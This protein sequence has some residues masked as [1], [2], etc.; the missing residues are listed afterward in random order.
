MIT[1]LSC[2]ITKLSSAPGLRFWSFP[3]SS[4]DFLFKG[5]FSSWGIIIS[6][7]S[8]VV[9]S[10]VDSGKVWFAI[11]PFWQETRQQRLSVSAQWDSVLNVIICLS[12]VYL[13]TNQIADSSMI[14]KT[15]IDAET[16]VIHLN[17]NLFAC[18]YWN[19]QAYV[20]ASSPRLEW[21]HWARNYHEAGTFHQIQHYKFQPQVSCSFRTNRN[22][23]W[24]VIA[25]SK[26][27][28]FNKR[29]NLHLSPPKPP[30]WVERDC[31]ARQRKALTSGVIFASSLPLLWEQRLVTPGR[32]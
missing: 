9:E 20:C 23:H 11:W 6:S 28:K 27:R 18:E 16:R 13:S 12:K 25:R 22:V 10:G 24:E 15:T 19:A 26:Q 32:K 21:Q 1:F 30:F 7:D 14:K 29:T 3:K 8:S 4:S 31:W 5:A 2:T 17:L